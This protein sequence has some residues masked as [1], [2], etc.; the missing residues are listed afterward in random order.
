LHKLRAAARK[1]ADRCQ[2]RRLVQRRQW[3]Q[4]IQL[5]ENRGVDPHGGTENMTAMNDPMPHCGER[6]LAEMRR[7]PVDQLDG[8]IPRI[9]PWPLLVCHG[10]TNTISN[11]Q[12]R[13][14]AVAIVHAASQ[15]NCHMISLEQ[16]EFQARGTNV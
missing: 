14:S 9:G 1:R 16:R 12:P 5:R 6:Y 15:Q 10:L 7:D 11:L 4:R 13:R 2:R 3:N 8:V